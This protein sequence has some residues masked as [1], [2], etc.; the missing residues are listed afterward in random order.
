[1][2]NSVSGIC[3]VKHPRRRRL[4][5]VEKPDFHNRTANEALP[6]EREQAFAPPTV[7]GKIFPRPS[8]RTR[9][10]AI[11]AS[12]RVQNNSFEPVLPIRYP[13]CFVAEAQSVFEAGNKKTDRCGS[14]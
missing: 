6:A 11:F 14:G 13:Q 2:S 4:F 10:Y 1:L 3:G 9:F 5:R 8:A 12:G 7:A